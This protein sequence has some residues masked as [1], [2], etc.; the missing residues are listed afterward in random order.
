MSGNTDMY[1]RTFADFHSH[2][3]YNFVKHK[4]SR[5]IEEVYLYIYIPLNPLAGVETNVYCFTGLLV[6]WFANCVAVVWLVCFD[7]IYLVAGVT[8]YMLARS[9]VRHLLRSYAPHVQICCSTKLSKYSYNETTSAGIHLCS[10]G[11]GNDVKMHTFYVIQF[12]HS[13]FWFESEVQCKPA[14]RSFFV[15]RKVIYKIS[16]NIYKISSK[17]S[18][19]FK[20]HGKVRCNII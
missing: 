17:H 5:E 16:N 4:R 2:D 1:M 6:C 18:T 14:H 9:S 3:T 12:Y 7:D 15:N 20:L 8:S 11:C 13:V 19:I 10:P